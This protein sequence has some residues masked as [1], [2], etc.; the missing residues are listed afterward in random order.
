M[1]L[2]QHIRHHESSRWELDTLIMNHNVIDYNSCESV[3]TKSDDEYVRMHFGL[4]GH[5]EFDFHN[6]NTTYNLSGHHNNILYSQGLE[7]TVRN[8]SERIE[9]FGVNFKPTTFLSIAQN[10]NDPLKQ[11]AEKVLNKTNTILSPNWKSNSIQIQQI[12]QDIL[13]CPYTNGLKN[14]F[15]FSKSLEL[16]VLQAEL[17]GEGKELPFIKTEND[18]KKLVEARD[19]LSLHLENPP[20]LNELSKLVGLNEYKL[21]RGFKELFQTT[22]FGFIHHERMQQAKRLLLDTDKSAKEIAYATGYSSPQHF[23]A[24]FKREFGVSPKSVRNNPDSISR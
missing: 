6:L 3:S 21:K 5:Y 4:L 18:R 15:L 23:S 14:L 11:L 7:M 2:P 8:K 12:I 20:S 16:L 1:S 22:V 19:Y 9:T 13:H 10:G 24:A 17:Y